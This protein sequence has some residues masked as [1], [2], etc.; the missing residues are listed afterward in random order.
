MGEWLSFGWSVEIE[1]GGPRRDF[2]IVNAIQVIA[3]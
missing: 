3:F 1:R 2:V